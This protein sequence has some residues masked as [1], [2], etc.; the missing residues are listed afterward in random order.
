MNPALNP[1][2]SPEEIRRIIALL[3]QAD[4][5]LLL[6]QMDR[7]PMSRAAEGRLHQTRAA[8]CQLEVAL[9]F[10]ETINQNHK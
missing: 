8:L 3:K 6:L 4:D 1:P 9:L 7:L 10:N 5:A 2:C